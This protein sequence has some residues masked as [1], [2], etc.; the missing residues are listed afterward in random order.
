MEVGFPFLFSYDDIFLVPLCFLIIYTFSYFV[1]VKYNNTVLKQYFM[2]ALL[3]RLVFTIIYAIIIQFYYGG[4]ADT[5]VYYQGVI[6]MHRAIAADGSAVKDIFL[7]ADLNDTNPIA[8]YLMYDEIPL[9]Y[10]FMVLNEPKNWMV[11]KFGLPF[12]IIFFKNYLCISLCI[13]LFAF[14]GC[15]RMFKTF[16]ALYPHLH[17]KIAIACLFLPSVIFW[18]V[19]LIKDSICIGALGFLFNALY[20]VFIQR[21]KVFASVIVAIISGWLLF[22]VKPYILFTFAPAF[23]VWLFIRFNRSIN[24]RTLRSIA[25]FLFTMLAAVAGFFLIQYM[26]TSES[27]GRFASENILQ[28]VQGQQS[29]YET[30]RGQGSA[31]SVGKAENSVGGLV[32]LFPQGVVASLF[33]PFPWDVRSPLMVLS[34]LE[35]LAFIV[36][37]YMAFRAIGFFK[38][39]RM[40]FTDPLTLFCFIYSILFAG[41]VGVTTSNFGALVRYKIPCLPFYLM[42]IFI[43]MDK[44]GKF[45]PKYIF[46]K[47]FF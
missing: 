36:L 27:S 26:T 41:F 42:M 6:D 20:Q 32:S 7:N 38:T 45:S 16:Y 21:K 24:D 22:S 14:A 40:I 23:L 1:R 31:F 39:F 34:A 12:S 47:K 25:G 8:P 19:G 15:W 13:S 43:I 30:V 37:T 44:S 9:G 35:A 18:G 3:L 10:T 4:Q 29:G 5:N 33:R 28:T 2:P 46:S 17:K 11:T